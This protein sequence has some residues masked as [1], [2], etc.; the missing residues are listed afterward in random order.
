MQEF[1][2][3]NNQLHPLILIAAPGRSSSQTNAGNGFI[4]WWRSRIFDRL[5]ACDNTRLDRSD[6]RSSEDCRRGK[7]SGLDF[8]QICFGGWFGSIKVVSDF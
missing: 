1:L 7:G 8:V 4:K 3:T 5:A 2:V 6:A